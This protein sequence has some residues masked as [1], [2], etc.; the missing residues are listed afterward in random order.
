MGELTR[1]DVGRAVRDALHDINNEMTRIR[2]AVTRVD[3]RTSDL[4]DSQREITALTQTMQQVIPTLDMLSR[5]AQEGS[6]ETQEHQRMRTDVDD[7]KQR[8]QNMERGILQIVSYLQARDKIDQKEQG[9][10]K[11]SE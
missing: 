11:G 4:D 6:N 1:D 2:D 5:H 7:I 10:R 3:Q 9:F 8:V